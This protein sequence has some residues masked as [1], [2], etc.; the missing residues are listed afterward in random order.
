LVVSEIALALVLLISAGMLG[1]TL[2]HL[3]SLDPGLNV[4]NVL[5]ARAGL[6]P[7]VLENSGRT[8][9]A[10]TNLLE[11]AR[12]VPGVQ[13][14][15]MV[16]TVPMREGNNPIGYATNAA[17][18]SDNNQPLVLANSV[19]PEYL[20]VMAI[21]LRRGR[22]FT[23]LDRMGAEP[24]VV[25]DEVMA[26]EA[27]R[28]QDPLGKHLWIGMG[29]DPLR[30]VGVVAHVR[31]WGPGDDNRTNVR[32]QLYYP[33]AQVPDQYVRRWSELM[34]IAVRTGVEPLGVVEPLRRQV[35]GAGGDQVLYD[36]HTLEQLSSSSLAR[37]RFL[38]LLFGVFASLALLLACI[39][40]Y[41]VLAYLTSQRVPE[42]GV[43][44]A[45]GATPRDVL[46][47]VLRQSLTLVGLGVVLGAGGSL[48]AGRV[49]GRLVE[50][51][52]PNAPFTFAAMTAVLIG[53][54]CFAGFLPARRAS[55]IDPVQALRQE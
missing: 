17:A 42:I 20:K 37:Q 8:R 6:S 29:T 47:M 22:F 18:A 35:R 36:V 2:L 25:I 34:S 23:D 30:V 46:W 24:V 11:Q 27:F 15:A 55:R 9:A 43:R 7:S 3:S 48:A 10:W 32:A 13:A 14:I 16:D 19:S 40:I 28:G 44:V 12:R 31:Y 51:M 1:R 52:Q 4:R 38:L 53:A 49:L 45:L 54:A 33:F 50:G 39:G 26:G 21:P 41:G 5:T